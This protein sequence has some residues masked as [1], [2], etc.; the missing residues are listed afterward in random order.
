MGLYGFRKKVPLAVI[1]RSCD[2]FDLPSHISIGAR[3]FLVAQVVA[4][5]AR[6]EVFLFLSPCL[7]SRAQP[8]DCCFRV[9]FSAVIL[10]EAKNFSC[11]KAKG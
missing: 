11:R 6:P 9:F 3:W 4:V 7:S 10:S 8:S 5:L 2:F 1:L